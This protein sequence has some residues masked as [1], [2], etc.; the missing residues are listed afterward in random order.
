MKIVNF[1]LSVY[2]LNDSAHYPVT[3]IRSFFTC[4]DDLTEEEILFECEKR[5]DVALENRFIDMEKELA[6]PSFIAVRLTGI[7]V[8]SNIGVY[9]DHFIYKGPAFEYYGKELSKE[10]ANEAWEKVNEKMK[11]NKWIIGC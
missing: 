4:D 1:F 10:E 8:I 6:D 3:E 7:E 11:N 5:V 2:H 9:H